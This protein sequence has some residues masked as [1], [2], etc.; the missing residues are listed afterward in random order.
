MTMSAEA[1][2]LG[3]SRSVVVKVGSSLIIGERADS[4]TDACVRQQWLQ[5]L[6]ADIAALS[7][8]GARVVV[9]TSGAVALGQPALG[10]ARNDMQ[11]AHK[12][13]AAA[14]GQVLLLQ[15]WKDALAAQGVGAAQVLLTPGDTANA[16]RCANACATLDALHAS[17]LIAV[18][19]ENDTVATDELRYG[20]N[21]Q[22]AARVAA[23]TDA[24][25]L[26]LLS[27]VEG[28][29]DV[30]P[31]ASSGAQHI[32]HVADVDR[33]L[34]Q[35]GTDTHSTYGTGGMRSKLLAAQLASAAGVDTVIASGIEAHP[36]QRL[37]EGARCTRIAAAR[38]SS[39]TAESA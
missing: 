31:R 39:A 3:G 9:V 36:L 7:H 30:D 23:M 27:D 5:S 21:D 8:A 6:A 12:Q 17:G 18:I 11:L 19:N 38:A 33:A 25:L 14:A 4:D 37:Q 24:Q 28:L 35:I 20:D 32:P 26:V 1:T 10:I 15:A 2:L 22:L 29:F 34:A 16:E 13:A